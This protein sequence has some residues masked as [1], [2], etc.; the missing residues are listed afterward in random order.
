MKN[1]NDLHRK[2][3]PTK[4]LSNFWRSIDFKSAAK[5]AESLGAQAKS[6]S[7]DGTQVHPIVAAAFMRWADPDKFYDKLK[8]LL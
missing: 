6:P 5:A 8:A 7:S 2:L 1:I 4:S 3:C